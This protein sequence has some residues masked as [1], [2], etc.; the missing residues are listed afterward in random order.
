MKTIASIIT[1]LQHVKQLNDDL[2]DLTPTLSNDEIVRIKAKMQLFLNE[3]AHGLAV[4]G[5]SITGE[6]IIGQDIPNNPD[7]LVQ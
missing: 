1:L 5:S 3:A 7:Q 4:V 2:E 6:P